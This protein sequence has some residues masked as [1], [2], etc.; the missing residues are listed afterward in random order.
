MP[1]ALLAEFAPNRA[2]PA[3][4]SYVSCIVDVTAD[5]G[6][7]LTQ[8]FA[9]QDATVGCSDQSPLRPPGFSDQ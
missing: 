7:E 5:C 1:G 2:C 9:V 6:A 4:N 3:K 8:Q